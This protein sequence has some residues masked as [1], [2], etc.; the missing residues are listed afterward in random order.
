MQ[1]RKRVAIL[2]LTAAI[3]LGLEHYLPW[4][5]SIEVRTAEISILLL[6]GVIRWLLPTAIAALVASSLFW[7][8]SPSDRVEPG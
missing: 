3:W 7:L 5:E 2:T 4:V 6:L 8:A 1:Q